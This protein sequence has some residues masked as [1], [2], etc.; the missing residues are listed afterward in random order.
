MPGSP[1]RGTTGPRR[2]AVLAT[3]LPLGLAGCAEVLA[4][5]DWLPP[6]VWDGPSSRAAV[7]VPPG[8]LPPH[9]QCRVWFPD[10][11]PGQQPPPSSCRELRR[12]VPDDAV[13]VRG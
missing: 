11:P 6:D 10:R 4:D 2:V 3:L 7:R 9:G 1:R 12:R 5:G 8:H 13:L